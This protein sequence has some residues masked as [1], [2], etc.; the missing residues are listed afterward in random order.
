MEVDDH[1]HCIQTQKNSDEQ[2]KGVVKI[3]VYMASWVYMALQG[4][5]IILQRS[6]K[7]KEKNYEL[8]VVA[9][10]ETTGMRGKKGR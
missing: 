3:W 1:V 8:Q 9:N 4:S 7:T 6:G 10:Y 2:I 5:T